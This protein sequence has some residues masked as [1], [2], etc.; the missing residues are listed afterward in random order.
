MAI[1]AANIVTYLSGGAANANVNAS[2]GGAKSSVAW[3]GGTLHDLFD[4]ISGDENA[5]SDVEYRCIYVQNNHGTLT[6]EAVKLWVS[7][8]TAGGAAIGIALAGEGVSAVAETVANE[9]TAPVGESF[10]APTSKATGL[11]IGN[12]A[13]A[14]YYGIWI[15]RSASNSAALDADGGTLSWSGDTAA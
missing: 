11:T 4:V 13:A 10:T 8:E 3:A 15:R 14:A 9:N 7:A 6:W 2:L 1:I 5:A 12:L